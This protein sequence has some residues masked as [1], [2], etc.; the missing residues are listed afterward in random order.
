MADCKR[1]GGLLEDDD[2]RRKDHAIYTSC[3]NHLGQERDRLAKERDAVADCGIKVGEFCG[4][5][6]LSDGSAVVC[7]KHLREQIDECQ[8]NELVALREHDLARAEVEKWKQAA[9]SGIGPALLG[10]DWKRRAEQAEKEVFNLTGRAEVYSQRDEMHLRMLERQRQTIL[11][12][13]Q[14]VAEQA[15]TIEALR[16]AWEAAEGFIEF[17]SIPMLRDEGPER[18]ERLDKARAALSKEKEVG[19]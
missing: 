6:K 8:K 10:V 11:E 14:K 5:P 18:L 16:E 12:A 2:R 19:K 1:C 7:C 17:L 15:R 13:G 3:I 4:Y 9:R